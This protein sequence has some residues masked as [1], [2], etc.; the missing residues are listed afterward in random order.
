MSA[1]HK[2]AA[3][4]VFSPATS[5]AALTLFTSCC[6]K[7]LIV[8][9]V[10]SD[11]L[12]YDFIILILLYYQWCLSL[13]NCRPCYLG[14]ITTSWVAL[15]QIWLALIQLS[16][17]LHQRTFA[18]HWASLICALSNPSAGCNTTVGCSLLLWQLFSH[19]VWLVNSHQ[20]N[21]RWNSSHC[22]SSR[23]NVLSLF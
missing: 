22:F 6:S 4:W 3:L 20:N 18:Y 16:H 14:P 5:D 13:Q 7:N 23:C 1:S 19:C 8:Y 21:L 12:I 9:D 2:S 11:L 10:Q 17:T 15:K